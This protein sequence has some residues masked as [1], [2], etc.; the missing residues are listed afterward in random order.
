MSTSLG[1]AW[2]QTELN[3]PDFLGEQQAWLSQVSSVQH[4]PG[5]GLLVPARLAPEAN[6]LAQA[7]FAIKHEGVRLDY[8][9]AALRR[10]PESEMLAAF[11]ATPNGTFVRKLCF[12]WEAFHQ[13]A[14]AKLDDPGVT[15]AYV[16]M[17]DPASYLTGT[18]RRNPRWRVDFNG[19]GDIAFC[20]IIRKTAAL[21]EALSRNVL[22][23]AAE[24]AESISQHL[25]ERPLSW[26]CLSET[27]GSF[28]IKGETPTQDKNA[29]FAKLLDAKRDREQPAGQG[30]AV[31]HGTKP[32]A[33]RRLG[34][35]GPCS[36]GVFCICDHS[37]L[38]GRQWQTLAFFDSSLPRSVRPAAGGLLASPLGGHAKT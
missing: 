22:A 30:C 11:Q 8:L 3:A 10:V 12:L 20:P 7:L 25:L 32:F 35:A 38:H 23:K 19:L 27:E 14:L 33:T 4:L 17:F 29:L 6:W 36:G 34:R 5:G 24:L 31:P 13:R 16:R 21:R 28:A 1:Y 15:A 26:A 2:I 37:S 18:S 9:A